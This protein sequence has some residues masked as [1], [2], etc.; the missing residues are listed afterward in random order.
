MYK[1]LGMLCYGFAAVDLGLYLLGI[2]DLTGVTWSPIAASM[3]GWVFM[4]R[5]E[6]QSGEADAQA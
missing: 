6:A 5:E 3:L 4:K 2:A 1:V